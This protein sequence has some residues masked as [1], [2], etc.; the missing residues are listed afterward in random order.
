MGSCNSVVCSKENHEVEIHKRRNVMRLKQAG[1]TIP[2]V[3]TSVDVIDIESSEESLSEAS[4]SSI[5]SGNKRNV[6]L[7]REELKALE[8]CGTPWPPSR[9]NEVRKAR[10]QKKKFFFSSKEGHQL[11]KDNMGDL[12][13]HRNLSAKEF[14]SEPVRHFSYSA[15]GPPPRPSPWKE[16]YLAM[17]KPKERQAE[18][19]M[20]ENARKNREKRKHINREEQIRALRKQLSTKINSIKRK[21][22]YIRR[23]NTPQDRKTEQ[24]T[25]GVADGGR[26]DSDK[27]SS[28]S[29]CP[30]ST[31]SSSAAS[32][33]TSIISDDSFEFKETSIGCYRG[34]DE[35][36]VKV[37]QEK[38]LPNVMKSLVHGNKGAAKSC[39]M[40]RRKKNKVFPM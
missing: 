7:P 12:S 13:E 32:D 2:N 20:K 39:G 21:T 14:S 40:F 19:S 35:S 9:N 10:L 4:S 23:H 1:D 33:S 3:S 34:G 15:P 27:R 28:T 30:A 25:L 29:I 16:I 6:A 31:T 18:G 24:D 36:T 37:S 8:I 26:D 17:I 11:K 38:M 5:L 22:S